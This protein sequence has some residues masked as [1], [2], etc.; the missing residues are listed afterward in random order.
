MA[1]CTSYKQVPYLQSGDKYPYALEMPMLNQQADKSVLPS[2]TFKPKDQLSISV[3]CTEDY[4]AVE[5]FNLYDIQELQ[6]GNRLG[7]SSGRIHIYEIDN[8]GNIEFPTL[9]MLHI[10]GL[11]R[12]QLADTIASMI[13]G[14]YTRERPEV[15]VRFANSTVAVLGDV[16]R[17]G[18]YEFKGTDRM[19]IFEALS[20][21]SDETIYGR[22]DCVKIIREDANGRKSVGEINLNDPAAVLS[23]YYY[24]QQSDVV[25]VEPNRTHSRDTNVGMDTRY[26]FRAASV[27]VSLASLTYMFLR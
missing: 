8:K 17:P 22:R 27:V 6:N 25:Y 5:L 4:H 21:A 13:V 20:M 11:T 18:R 26:W 10:A 15:V 9:G 2:L 19:T 3:I 16:K 24:L 7:Y 23:P 1:S 12:E 14:T